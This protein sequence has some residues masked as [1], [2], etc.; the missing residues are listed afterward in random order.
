VRGGG[1]AASPQPTTRRTTPAAPRYPQVRIRVA[2][3]DGPAGILIGKVAV[4][5][6]YRVGNQAA[7]TFNTAAH[8]CTTRDQLL[9]LI[10][11]TVRTR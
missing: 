7:D 6:R 11:A 3:G 10:R 4:A 9:W 8:A 5:L 1:A 2:G